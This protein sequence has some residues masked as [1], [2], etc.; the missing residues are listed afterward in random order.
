M[1]ASWHIETCSPQRYHCKHTAQ[2]ART[3]GALT[4][5][6]RRRLTR[7]SRDWNHRGRPRPGITA[8]V[9]SRGACPGGKLPVTM[10]PA[11]A[12][13]RDAAASQISATQGMRAIS[14]FFQAETS[15]N[16]QG[17]T[18]SRSPEGPGPGEGRGLTGGAAPPPRRRSAAGRAGGRRRQLARTN[19]TPPTSRCWPSWSRPTCS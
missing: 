1:G 5:T 18:R 9:I 13:A 11:A 19:P 7:H 2:H 4:L 16:T 6:G 15:P 3:P 12:V 17:N 8:S 10:R 14:H